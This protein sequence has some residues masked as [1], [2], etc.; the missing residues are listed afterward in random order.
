MRMRHR[1]T[2]VDKDSIADELSIE[3]GSFLISING[4]DIVDIVDYEQL[5]TA[6]NLVVAI[7]TPDGEIV[8]ADIE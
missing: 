1:I 2:G 7:E 3:P 6:E 4:E 5:C 8:E